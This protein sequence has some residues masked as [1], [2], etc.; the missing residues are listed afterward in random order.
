M[1]LIRRCE[2]FITPRETLEGADAVETYLSFLVIIEA[3]TA[4]NAFLVEIYL[5]NVF[6]QW[7]RIKLASAVEDVGSLYGTISHFGGIF[8]SAPS[9]LKTA[10]ESTRM[11]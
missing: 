3:Q 1:S 11:Q 7:Q 8:G 9:E 10:L 4:C 5:E 6:K 2:L